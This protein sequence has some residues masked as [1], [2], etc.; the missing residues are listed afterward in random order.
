MAS[1]NP[2][3]PS[4]GGRKVRWLAGV[5]IV[6]I[7]LY[8]A[9]WF[10]AAHR[11]D[12]FVNTILAQ[13]FNNVGAECEGMAVGGF[14]FLIGLSCDQTNIIDD[15][16]GIRGSF[17]AMRGAAR[18]YLP[19]TAIV[20]IDGP[21]D[22]QTEAGIGL[23][24]DWKALRASI[25]ANLD[26][27]ERASLEGHNLA[28]K[29]VS[30]I[31]F[32]AFNLDIG[33]FELHLRAIGGDL[34]TAFVTETVNFAQEG[35]APALP[36]FSASVDMSLLAKGHILAGRPYGSK[37]ASGQLRALK[38]D[39]GKGIYGELSGPFTIDEDGWISGDLSLMLEN[40]D[41]WE[42]AL[43]TA[44][45]D[46][47]PTLSGIAQMLRGLSGDKDR[48]IVKL[49]VIK[50]TILLSLLPIGQIPQM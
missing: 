12:G 43:V 17:G 33:R 2:V 1:N 49:S 13:G 18:I 11:L 26:G 23:S 15:A 9:G 38:L 44:F 41:L 14:P 6:F 20:E 36:P 16:Q 40:L 25:S 29:L 31:S 3:I 46:A 4:K 8:C 7:G 5:I 48:T 27:L 35:F 28:A 50:G 21:A 39:M 37:K 10:Y 30:A 42:K 47:A 32:Q 19:G 22:I 24:G 34:D 45:P